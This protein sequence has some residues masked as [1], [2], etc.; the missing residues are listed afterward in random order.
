MGIEFGVKDFIVAVLVI[1][2]LCNTF[3]INLGISFE[4]F[5]V[6]LLDR[7]SDGVLCI[8]FYGSVFDINDN[9]KLLG[10]G[11][12]SIGNQEYSIEKSF[13]QILGFVAH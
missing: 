3:G 1:H 12:K 13:V 6:R 5:V 9:K 7:E 11:I 8:C 2:I 4:I 10:V